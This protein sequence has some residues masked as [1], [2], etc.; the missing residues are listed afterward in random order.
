ML[1]LIWYIIVGLIAG[2]VAQIGHAHP[3]LSTA[4]CHDKKDQRD[5]EF[6][7]AGS[8]RSLKG[9]GCNDIGGHAWKLANTL[10]VSRIC[11]GSAEVILKGTLM[12]GQLLAASTG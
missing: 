4:N 8:T 2:G 3:L 11:N 1:H 9:P 12:S 6:S 10:N 7:L 5:P